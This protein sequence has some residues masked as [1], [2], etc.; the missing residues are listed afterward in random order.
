MSEVLK[1]LEERFPKENIQPYGECLIIPLKQLSKDQ[2][3]QLKSQG[4]RIRYQGYKGQTCAFIALGNGEPH[5]PSEPQEPDAVPSDEKKPS[6]GR[7]WSEQEVTSLKELYSLGVPVG[8]IAQ[9]L[10]RS[11]VAVESKCQQLVLKRSG[12]V[13]VRKEPR[14]APDAPNKHA[15]PKANHNGEVVRDCLFAAGLLY[16]DHVHAAAILLK[17]AAAQMEAET[18]RR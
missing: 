12:K 15:S 17:E 7:A 10:D 9:K 4:L 16:P 5:E 2:E 14:P 11:K 18:I 13:E 8:E 1:D 3:N 6:N